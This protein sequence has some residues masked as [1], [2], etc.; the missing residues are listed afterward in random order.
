MAADIDEVLHEKRIERVTIRMADSL[1]SAAQQAAAMSGTSLGSYINII[2]A[3][4]CAEQGILCQ[5]RSDID[6][7]IRTLQVAM[8]QA[9]GMK[10][11]GMHEQ[12]RRTA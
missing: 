1:L 5:T 4:S 12:K 8:V 2:T 9:R 10:M 6:D 11:A 3:R 7:L